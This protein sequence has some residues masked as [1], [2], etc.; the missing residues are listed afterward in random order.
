MGSGENSVAAATAVVGYDLAK[1]T[2]WQQTGRH[3]ALKGVALCGSAAGGDT[4][5]SIFVDTVKV[6]EIYNTT[7]G[8]PTRDHLKE[9]G[10]MIPANSRLHAYVDDAPSTNPI[11][12]MFEWADL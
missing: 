6:S 12:I 11:N 10:A 9:I 2:I 4:K 3:R 5:V 8:F 7:T 1:D